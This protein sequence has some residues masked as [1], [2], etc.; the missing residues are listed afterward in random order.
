[1]RSML[2]STTLCLF[3]A[4]AA[5]AAGFTA[6]ENFPVTA[7]YGVVGDALPDGRLV[8]WNGA[9]VYFQTLPGGDD[10]TP[11]AEGYDGDP[12]FAVVAPDGHTV[13]MGA[14]GFTD[15]Y[16]DQI[17]AFDA[18]APADYAP[19]S[20]VLSRT[21]Y[22]CVFLTENLIL[23]DAGTPSFA[24]E[25]VIM[26]LAAKSAPVP[27]V[28]KPVEYALKAQV[29]PKPG[30]A[31]GL[32]YD[33]AAGR[34]Y[35][36]DAATLELR[37]FDV[38]DLIGALGG[39]NG[40]PIGEQRDI[41]KRPVTAELL[42]QDLHRL[43]NLLQAHA[44][45]EQA[46]DH[47]MLHDVLERVQTLRSRTLR[48][49]NRRRQQSGPGPIVQLPVCDPDDFAD[50]RR[51]IPIF[52]CHGHAHLPRSLHDRNSVPGNYRRETR[53]AEGQLSTTPVDKS[54]PPLPA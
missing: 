50:L 20:V 12:A 38:D 41:G 24:S 53:S 43:T 27:V 44:G 36:M 19:E 51:P 4:T 45:I 10:F 15:P 22:S 2:F 8:V 29:V 32:A 47:S 9:T 28:T 5:G 48:R 17:Y 3:V 35:A 21:H 34:V 46:F 49:L 39:I 33:Q 16:T 54:A 18:D 31:A 25:L 52:L 42:A 30:Y 6:Y 23:I 26:D 40:G 7:K 14:G 1:M 37:W 11:V 13:L